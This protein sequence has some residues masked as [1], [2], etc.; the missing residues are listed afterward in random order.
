MLGVWQVLANYWWEHLIPAKHAIA[1][2][3][4]QLDDLRPAAEHPLTAELRFR[5]KEMAKAAPGVY[6]NP[7]NA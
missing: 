6:F 4:Y 5:S 2:G 1:Q 3:D 7:E